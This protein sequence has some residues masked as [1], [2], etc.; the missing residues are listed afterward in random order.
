MRDVYIPKTSYQRDSLRYYS[1][2][3]NNFITFLFSEEAIGIQFLK[4]AGLIR[5]KVQ[6]NS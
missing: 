2:E 5:G 6:C 4:D 3:N 1:D